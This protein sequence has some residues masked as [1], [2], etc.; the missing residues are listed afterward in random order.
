MSLEEKVG[1]LFVID[2]SSYSL[3]SGEKQKIKDFRPGGIM[4]FGSNLKD[5]EQIA[6]FS[7]QLQE[8]AAEKNKTKR[9]PL[10][11]ATDQEPGADVVRAP[12]TQLPSN[13][14]LGASSESISD[15]ETAAH[16]TGSELR[17]MGINQN[18]APVVDVNTNPKNP[19]IGTRSFGDDPDQVSALASKQVAVFQGEENTIA[20]AK[21]FPGHGD[22]ST[23]SH[24]NLPV[25][26][27]SRE[28]LEK[29]DLPPFR[30][31]IDA[32]VGVIM[33]AHIAVPSID[34][35]RAPATLSKPIISG[36][37]RGELGFD[38]VVVTDALNMAG[39]QSQ[40]PK[41][42]VVVSA[43]EAG[44]DQLLMPPSLQAARDSIIDA[45][46][47]GELSEER[48][49]QSVR[50]ILKLKDRFNLFNSAPVDPAVAAQKVMTPENA[51]KAKEV[52]DRTITLLKNENDALP[53]NS[54]VKNV[55]VTGMDED[56]NDDFAKSLEGQGVSVTVSGTRANPDANAIEKVVALAKSQDA[57]V[58]LPGRLSHGDESAG[59]F[60]L[61]S[62][63][64]AT[65]KPL[66]I[67]GVFTP[68][69]A[70]YIA[71]TPELLLTYSWARVSLDSLAKVIVGATRPTGTLPIN[72]PSSVGPTTKAFSRG[73]GITYPA[74]RG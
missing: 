23:D 21:H 48:I 51:E 6:E 73:A 47:S 19:V 14:A 18:F 2:V 63:L 30:A 71:D 12:G 8:A 67:A 22:T 34:P 45:V 57:V 50:R 32:G 28:D 33:T 31:A 46:H 10:L 68:Y 56:V 54:K 17:A 16:I 24:T 52:S 43:L 37:L 60:E 59:Q 20:T 25:I 69:D 15:V 35:T 29:N 70:A 64:Q 65:G 4:Y 58:A 5:P 41:K 13:M 40:D 7:N 42:S 62:Q 39:V 26:D 53:L 61:I 38:G 3:T 72:I 55:L 9:I 1:Q 74:T 44:V 49:N 27:R 66:I 11:I 36:L